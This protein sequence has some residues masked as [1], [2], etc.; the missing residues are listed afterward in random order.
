MSG[1]VSLACLLDHYVETDLPLSIAGVSGNSNSGRS[2]LNKHKG[3]LSSESQTNSFE[4]QGWAAGVPKFFAVETV[5]AHAGLSALAKSAPERADAF[6]YGRLI[7]LCAVRHPEFHAEINAAIAET[8]NIHGEEL[9]KS[10]I[11]QKLRIRTERIAYLIRRIMLPTTANGRKYF[12][13]LQTVAKASS[14]YKNYAESIG[15]YFDTVAG[16]L[17]R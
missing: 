3:E 13:R 7:A 14:C 8:K 12:T 5:W 2:A 6:N 4:N 17:H 11:W 16:S 9:E 15:L 1:A 10:L